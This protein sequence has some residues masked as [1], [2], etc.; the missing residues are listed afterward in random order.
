MLL[1]SPTG[2]HHPQ[3][4]WTLQAVSMV[5]YSI[6]IAKMRTILYARANLSLIQ[7]TQILGILKNRLTLFKT[8]PRFRLSDTLNVFA[9]I[10]DLENHHYDGS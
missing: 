6:S 2:G 4:E 3:C 1:T 7:K 8:L 9:R 10:Q 5:T